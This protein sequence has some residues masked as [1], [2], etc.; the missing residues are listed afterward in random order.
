MANSRRKS[1]PA[2]ESSF[3]LGKKTAMGG[4]GIVVGAIGITVAI[5]AL[6]RRRTA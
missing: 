2:E 1:S 3:H 6:V 5:V 4:S